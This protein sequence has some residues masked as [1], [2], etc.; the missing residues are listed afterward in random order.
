[1]TTPLFVVDA[2]GNYSQLPWSHPAYQNM[3]QP[4]DN[5]E[6]HVQMHQH[7]HHDKS[8]L[9]INPMDLIDWKGI[10]WHHVSDWVLKPMLTG[11]LFGMGS[12]AS[13][14]LVH[15]LMT[16]YTTSWH[17]PPH[18]SLES[19][20]AGTS[21]SHT[22]AAQAT[23]LALIEAP[24]VAA[25]TIAYTAAESMTPAAGLAT[26][27]ALGG[28]SEVISAQHAHQSSQQS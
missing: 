4:N 15:Y 13:R 5:I 18:F 26:A 6:T 1:M 11:L 14:Y 8:Q 28:A 2:H 23:E 3:P 16:T 10:G 7:N 22:E 21:V 27:S 19:Q 20:T 25:E 17:V 12:Y 24:S 9:A